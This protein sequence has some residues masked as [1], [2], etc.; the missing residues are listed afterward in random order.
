MVSVGATA[1]VNLFLTGNAG[2]TVIVWN[3]APFNEFVT[4]YNSY[5]TN[6]VK[7]PM[8]AFSKVAV[9]FSRGLGLSYQT[10]KSVIGFEFNKTAFEQSTTGLFNNGNG[11][12]IKL[13]FVNWNSNFDFSKRFGKTIDF[14]LLIGITLRYGKIFSYATYNN[15]SGRSLGPEFLINGIYNSN[16][17]M[18]C[19][20]GLNLRVN[21][22]KYVA[23]QFRAYR[24]F[25]F[26]DGGTFGD[27]S[28]GKNLYSEYFP[29]NLEQFEN[30]AQNAVYDYEENV[31]ENK[32]PAWYVQSSLILK[33]PLLKNK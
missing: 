24:S 11:R 26:T 22:W 7:Q 25:A 13:R 2:A 10:E 15:G 28:P 12:E 18:D 19:N 21:L 32:F 5:I 8:G 6:N 4:S 20:L 33:L 1:Q 23:L 16:L 27:T 9:G 31:I 17:Q 29:K 30:N 3:P 14:G